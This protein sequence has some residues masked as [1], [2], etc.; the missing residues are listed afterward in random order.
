MKVA[1]F[2]APK[3]WFKFDKES[4]NLK[5][6][7]RILLLATSEEYIINILGVWISLVYVKNKKITKYIG[8]IKSL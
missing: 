4:I 7:K 1:H 8:N 6:Q 3:V 5:K 2:Y